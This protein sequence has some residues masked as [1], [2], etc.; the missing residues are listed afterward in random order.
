MK[1]IY[2]NKN[3]YIM[4]NLVK[5]SKNIFK[6]VKNI[7]LT[8]K[9]VQNIPLGRWSINYNDKEIEIKVRLANEDNGVSF[10]KIKN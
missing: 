3:N 6:I 7:T 4:Y 9:E 5:F 10:L 8:G 2:I 1:F